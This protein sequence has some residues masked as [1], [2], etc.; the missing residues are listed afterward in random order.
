MATPTASQSQ[1]HIINIE[2]IIGKPQLS[3]TIDGF[4]D[5]GPL[6]ASSFS[7]EK[8]VAPEAGADLFA[9]ATIT[10]SALNITIQKGGFISDLRNTFLNGSPIAQITLLTLSN[11][12]GTNKISDRLIFNNCYLLSLDTKTLAD[13][14]E[15]A[16][17]NIRYTKFTHTVFQHKQ[18]GTPPGQNESMFDLATNTTA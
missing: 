1:S 8:I 7:F 6:Y 11:V 12:G 16:I 15:T 2:T 3:S 14:T 4:Q 10:A 13:G 5:Y 9:S 17:L 18:D